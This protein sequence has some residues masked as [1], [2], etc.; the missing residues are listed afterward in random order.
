MVARKRWCLAISGK[1]SANDTTT[2]TISASQPQRNGKQQSLVAIRLRAKPQTL[3]D[4]QLSLGWSSSQNFVITRARLEAKDQPSV[5]LGLAQASFEQTGFP[6]SATLDS[7]AKSGWAVAGHAGKDCEITWTLTKPLAWPVEDSLQ[8]ILEQNF[9]SHHLLRGFELSLAFDATPPEQLAQQRIENVRASFA[10][11]LD[12][13]RPQ[14]ATWQLENP[15]GVSANM[16]R[17]QPQ[18]DGSYLAIGD[19]S[20]RDE[21][22][23]QMNLAAGTTAIMIEGLTDPSL[24]KRGPGRTYYEG[25]LG[26]F[27]L[28]EIRLRSPSSSDN[29]IDTA[30][31]DFAQAGREAEKALDGDPLTGWSIDGQQGSDHRMVVRLKEPLAQAT[32]A[33]LVL[34]FERY[35]A[36]PLG[37]VR[38]WTTTAKSLGKSSATI[39]PQTQ[40]Q[41]ASTKEP[42]TTEGV[43]W[44]LFL[45]QS[46]ELTSINGRIKEL[47]KSRPKHPTTLVMQPRPDGFVRATHRYHRGEFLNRAKRFPPRYPNSFRMLAALR[48]VTGWS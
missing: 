1:P 40:N 37:R 2:I 36:A 10:K 48:R 27:F 45:N 11:W 43:A 9:G 21:Y 7:D 35:Y 41:I 26:D 12:N 22:Q 14:I 28:S 17:L 6:A 25:P 13:T 30:W 42:G 32:Q 18:S 38:L 23:F 8:L 47:E 16:A 34:L 31:V 4:S 33:T 20:K 24:P 19:I 44:E 39:A 46:E 5:S 3:S 15:Q 29:L